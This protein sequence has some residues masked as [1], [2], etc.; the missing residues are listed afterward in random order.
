MSAGK[1]TRR[2]FNAAVG[3]AIGAA[4]APSI[5]RSQTTMPSN[6]A[7]LTVHADAPQHKI[8]RHLY[9]HFAEHL[10]RCIYEGIWVGEDSSI[11]H[12]RG[13]RN[14][15]VSALRNLKIPNLR[16]PGGCFADEYHWR[17]GIGPREKRPRRINTHWGGVTEPN[18]F[19]THEFL[20]LCEQLGCEPY[21]SGN[22]GSGTVR[23]MAEWIEYITLPEGSSLAD[24]R[25]A[26]GR[27]KPWKIRFWGVGNENWGC[28]GHMTPE[29]YVNE[30][31]RYATYCRNYGDNKLYRIAC[32]ANGN[33]YRWTDVVME[34]RAANLMHGISVHYYTTIW[35][36]KGSATHFEQPE[37]FRTLSLA[38]KLQELLAKHIA[39]MDKHDP[40]KRVGLVL[41]EWGTWFDVEPNT[42]P[43]FLYQQN[44]MRDA[45]VAGLSLNIL[46]RH[47]DRVSMA[48]IAQVVN[49][50]QAVILTEKEKMVLTPTY[51]VFEMFKVHHDAKYLASETESPT[52]EVKGESMPQVN[53]SASTDEKG[54]VHVSLCNLHHEQAATVRCVLRG[55]KASQVSGR[56]LT[57]PQIN[58]FNAFDAPERAKPVEFN[59]AKVQGDG[60]AV[61]LPAKSVVVLEIS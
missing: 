39:M 11:P 21:I 1:P 8:S 42:N 46:H 59:G 26:N 3:A 47:A 28:G 35:E 61:D 27:E 45:L 15:V 4:V 38:S 10:G 49:V 43:G 9:G 53:A 12:T 20:D 18:S 22:V 60:L 52:Y 29:Y 54:K 31:R 44:T 23:E 51:H 37:W 34:K 33:D 6:S 17:D 13:I 14:D 50:L 48:N 36:H 58:T 30:F 25:R 5:S 41:D 57:T 40:Q 55:M 24:E 32:G 7:T 16:W 19:G 2:Q 56:V